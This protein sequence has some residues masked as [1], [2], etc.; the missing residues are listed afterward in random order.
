M[1]TFHL[2]NSTKGSLAEVLRELKEAHRFVVGHCQLPVPAAHNMQWAIEMK[3]TRISL[4]VQNRPALVGKDSEQLFEAVNLL[5]TVERLIDA[6]EWF[7]HHD[8]FKDM[9]VLACHPSTSS[10]TGKAG[11][12]SDLVLGHNENTP[13]V[14][15]E[16]SDI[17]SSKDGN[18]KEKRDLKSLGYDEG[19]GV[20]DDGKRRFLCLSTQFAEPRKNK[21]FYKEGLYGT[22]SNDTTLLEV[23]NSQLSP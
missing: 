2:I 14:L 17:A 20:P 9:T 15:C 1:S 23:V 21:P 5:A 6:L 4:P 7:A 11:K 18:K 12:G 22:Q 19:Y 13:L 8:E 3:R 16:V 10:G